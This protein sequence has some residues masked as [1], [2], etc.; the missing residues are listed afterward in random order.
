MKT[1]SPSVDQHHMPRLHVLLLVALLSLSIG[2]ST[3]TAARA[4]GA[5]IAPILQAQLA[6]LRTADRVQ[7][8][9]N[10]HPAITS[11]AALARVIQS[12]GAGTVTFNNLDSVGVLATRSQINAVAGL[13]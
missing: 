12:L 13:V 8:V 7:A 10:F 11:G 3:Q 9:V 2:L 4:A 6:T 1:F 5:Y